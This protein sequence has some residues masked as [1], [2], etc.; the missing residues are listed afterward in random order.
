MLRWAGCFLRFRIVISLPN[1]RIT[2]TARVPLEGL[3]LGGVDRVSST[4]STIGGSKVEDCLFDREAAVLHV[5][6]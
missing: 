6:G 4:G 5:M 1:I 2:R 3:T